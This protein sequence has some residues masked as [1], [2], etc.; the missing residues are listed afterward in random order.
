SMAKSASSKLKDETPAERG[1][2]ERVSGGDVPTYYVNNT[3]VET[4]VWDIRLKLAETIEVD[5]ERR[6]T[7]VRELASVRMSPQ[8]AKVVVAILLRHLENYETNFGKIPEPRGEASAE[9]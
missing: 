5:A 9:G 6:I 1:T 8:H 7:R 3:A 4:T 2:I